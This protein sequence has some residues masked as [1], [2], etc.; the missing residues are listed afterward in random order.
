MSATTSSDSTEKVTVEIRSELV[1]IGLNRPDF[2]NRVDPDTLAALARAYFDYD[3]DDSLRAAVLFGHGPN[4][5]RGIDVDAFSELGRSGRTFV[6][7]SNMIDPLAK[8]GRLRKPLIVATH[9][10]TWNMGHE[11]HLVGDIRVTSK[12]VQFGQDEVSHGRFP[13]GGA[14]VRFVRDAGWANAMRYMLAGEHW[15]AAE[16]YR[17]GEV[18]FVADDPKGAIEMALQIASKIANCAPLGIAT[19]LNSAHLAIDSG[20][21]NALSKLDAQYGALYQTEDFIEGRKAEAEGR[22]PHYQGR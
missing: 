17:M 4:F 7:G 22:L 20:E 5:S 13:G 12:D 1:L 21:S 9:G 18:Q 19:T 2:Y 15:D 6:L 11:L 10:E 8:T 14:T 16:A 3:N